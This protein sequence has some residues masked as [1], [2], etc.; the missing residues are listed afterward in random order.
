MGAVKPVVRSLRFKWG[1]TLVATSLVGIV[2][3]GILAAR[4]HSSEYHRFRDEEIKRVFVGAALDFYET[5]RSW[6]DI[7]QGLFS[8]R[9]YDRHHEQESPFVIADANGVIV[10]AAGAYQKGDML[11]ASDIG[12]SK[13]ITFDGKQ[14]A[15]LI[16]LASPELDEAEARFLGRTRLILLIGA[17]GAV[18]AAVVLGT[19]LSRQ[20]LRPLA[21][22]TDAIGNIKQG[23]FDQRVPVRS[24]DELGE[25]AGAF[26]QMSAELQRI[27]RLRRQMITDIAHDL[28]TPLTVISGYLEGLR[29]GS[30]QPT[31]ARFDTLYQEAQLLNRLIDDLRT[32]SLADAGELK[33][34]WCSVK[35][36]DLLEQAASSFAP[37]AAAQS[38]TLQVDAEPDLPPV[39][40]DPDR[41]AQVLENLV[42]N[43]LRFTAPD[44][45]I[46]L[47]AAR[48]D[49]RLLLTVRDTGSGI[50]PEHLQNIFARFYRV[51]E[52][53]F[54][55]RGESGLGL[56]IAE[57]I[58]AAHGGQISAESELGRGTVIRI[59]LPLRAKPTGSSG[60]KRTVL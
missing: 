22:L 48:R 29:D 31:A 9:R 27:N 37:M 32:L 56:A 50:P 16:S 15:T 5:Y 18:V 25:L 30:L 47:A 52:S 38:V 55:N 40:L 33:L 1:L 10:K 4:V 51:S 3:V 58:V 24:D 54:Q 36:R 7:E 59:R 43:S 19:F 20:F 14:V 28:R 34:V 6:D 39:T 60:A 49:D 44:G 8:R 41:M 13:A 42:S 23:K 2:L 17:L 12:K 26:N 45:R 21:E 46:T 35:P 53:R 11:S 57:S